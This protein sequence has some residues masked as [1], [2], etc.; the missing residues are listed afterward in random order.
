MGKGSEDSN[1]QLSK[2]SWNEVKRHDN[3]NDLWIVIDKYVYDI[4]KFQKVHPGGA[5]VVN[6]YSGQDA[7]VSSS[8]F[9]SIC[10]NSL[11]R[12]YN[13]KRL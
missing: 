6:F 4:T 5:R 12:T 9:V 1:N 13:R 11:T 10:Y 8:Y 7:T 2:Y 3:K